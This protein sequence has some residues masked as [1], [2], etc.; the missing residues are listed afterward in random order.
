LNTANIRIGFLNDPTGYQQPVGGDYIPVFSPERAGLLYI[1]RKVSVPT[2]A[3]GTAYIGSGSKGN[4]AWI[5]GINSR[6]DAPIRKGLQP[7][8]TYNALVYYAPTAAETWQVQIAYCEYRGLS[9]GTFLNGA[10]VASRPFAI[11]TTQGGGSTVFQSDA[12]IRYRPI[13]MELPFSSGVVN[14]YELDAPIRF[15]GESN[16]GAFTTR[17]GDILPGGGVLPAPGMLLSFTPSAG[18]G[19]G[20]EVNGILRI[21]SMPIGLKTA[22]LNRS[23]PYLAIVCFMAKKGDVERLVIATRVTVGDESIIFDSSTDTAFDIFEV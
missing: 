12:A 11:Y 14:P 15:V 9:D 19:S 18:I 13:A 17:E 16:L 10:T 2:D 5:E 22:P 21:G 6:I 7:N 1:L 3:N 20:R 8:A 4:F 23:K